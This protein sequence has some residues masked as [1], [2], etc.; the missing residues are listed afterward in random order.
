VIIVTPR[1][2]RPLVPGALVATPLDASAPPNDVDLFLNGKT[3]IS[4]ANLRRVAS[5]RADM[6]RSG[7]IIDF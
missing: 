2:V 1:L 5:A 6:P 3:E 4:R 7:H